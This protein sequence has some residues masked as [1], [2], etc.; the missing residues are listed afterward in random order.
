MPL[1][2][3]GLKLGYVKLGHPSLTKKN[4]TL[5]NKYDFHDSRCKCF[6]CISGP[7]FGGSA[8]QFNENKINN[9]TDMH[10]YP[11]NALPAKVAMWSTLYRRAHHPI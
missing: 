6:T 4:E 2:G 1:P 7:L 3:V 8:E 10:L 9:N 11:S 5:V